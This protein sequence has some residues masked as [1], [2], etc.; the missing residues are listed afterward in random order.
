MTCHGT[1]ADVRHQV[2]ISKGRLLPIDASNQV[3]SKFGIHPNLPAVRDLYDDGDLLFFA[4]TGVMSQPVTKDNYYSLTK[5]QLFA[6]NHMQRETTRIDP[7]DLEKG[8][9]I[10]GRMTDILSQRGHTVGSFS[11]DRFTISLVGKPGVADFSPLIV[12]RNGIPQVY[13]DDV[14]GLMD[15]LNN[16]TNN[17]SG[18]FAE[19]WSTSLKESIGMNELLSSRLDGIT[20]EVEFPSTYFGDSLETIARLIAT[21]ETR[22][23]DTD[24]FYIEMGGE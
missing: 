7:Y 4:N 16:K 20:T 22:G 19:I 6:H 24:T 17:D 3:C 10:L 11:V 18:G 13:L 14:Q 23:V 9:G 5:T 15:K 21:R 12:D 1:S 8:T 2:A